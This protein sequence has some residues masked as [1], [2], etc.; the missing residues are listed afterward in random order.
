M[1]MVDGEIASLVST[2]WR[3]ANN[4]E[5]FLPQARRKPIAKAATGKQHLSNKKKIDKAN[6]LLFS[7]SRIR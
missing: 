7:F 3:I 4:P 5:V 1:A 2:V 6:I